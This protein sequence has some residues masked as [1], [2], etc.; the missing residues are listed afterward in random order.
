MTIDMTMLLR[1]LAAAP[2][3]AWELPPDAIEAGH[4]D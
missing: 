2:A 4:F 3:C 1:A